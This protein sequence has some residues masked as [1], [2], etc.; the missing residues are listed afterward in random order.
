MYLY[1]CVYIYI[2]LCIEY[3]HLFIG[4][5]CKYKYDLTSAWCMYRSRVV[6]LFFRS[7]GGGRSDM[8][9]ATNNL[10]VYIYIVYTHDWKG[11]GQFE[12]EFI[13]VCRLRVIRSFPDL[14][15][16][17]VGSD[18]Y[19]WIYIYVH[20]NNVHLYWEDYIYICIHI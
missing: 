10:Y 12:N 7:V 20:M 15:V 19:I 14:V 2:Y 1:I 4:E 6:D 16:A 18:I 9:T 5:G 13:Y 8:P 11:G 17:G 3:S